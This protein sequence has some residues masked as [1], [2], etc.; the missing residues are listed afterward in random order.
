MRYRMPAALLAALCSLLI[1]C[2]SP[3]ADSAKT[4][5]A[6]NA[7]QPAVDAAA[8]PIAER[9][10]AVERVDDAAIIANASHGRE[11]LTY[12][13]GFSEQRYSRLKQ[14]NVDNVDRLGLAWSYNLGSTRGVEATPVVV[15][16]TMYVTAS[17]S[18]VHALDARTGEK[19][20]QYDPQ[21][22]REYGARACCDVVNRGVA[23]AKGKVFVGTLDGYLVALDPAT[24]EV[25]WRTDTFGHMREKKLQTITGAPR[26]FGD[27][28]VIGNGGA[29]LQT[30]GYLTAYNV[31]TGEQEWRWYSVPE[32]PEP[33]F[34]DASMEMAAKTWDPDGAWRETGGGG[35]MWDSMAYDPELGLLY[36]GV[37]NGNP[38]NQ[39]VRSPKGGDN[40]FLSSIVALKA[41]TGEYVWH[42]QEVPGDTW[43]FT[44]AQHIILADLEIDGEARKVLMHAPKNGFFFVIDRTDGSFISAE[45]FV[46]VNWAE[47]YDENGRPI[48]A[49]GARAKK[50]AREMRPSAYGAHNWHPMS[51]NPETGLV[52]IPAQGVPLAME[53]DPSFQPN[54]HQPGHPM[55]NLG[56]NIGHLVNTITPEAKPFGHLLAWD[57]VAQKE[58]WRQEYLSPWNGGTTTTAGGLVFQGSADARFIAYDAK[59]GDALWQVPVSSGV[60]AGP[61]TFEI[62]G[63]QYVS[64]AVGWG[65][66]YGLAQ[67]HSERMGTGRV[68]TFRLDGE[69]KM[70]EIP[71]AEDVRSTTLVSGYEYEAEDVGPGAQLYV[72]SCIFC[73]GVPGVNNGGSLPNPGYVDAS[74]LESLP[75]LLIEGAWSSRGMPSFK[76]KLSE[77]EA[78]QVAAFIQNTAESVA[79]QSK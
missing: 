24:G 58:V 73:H 57:P 49:E 43:D 51:F 27:L 2:S 35:T 4:E 20:W 69:A 59:T 38:W 61:S 14:I 78:E 46:D 36:V 17:W 22:P 26:V 41:K 39:D 63:T 34:A 6:A 5:S 54:T 31:H 79:K 44:A 18:V 16:D 70:P 1:A 53:S 40:L 28:V 60:I 74:V 30:R 15:G 64:I 56:W 67:R 50:A 21:V 48:I 76:G 33:P 47:G 52:Y 66:V 3:G 71:R 19:L 62:D 8:D 7:T 10:A 11:W 72:S 23:V 37:G 9:R 29:E 75:T 12:N 45:P 77:R 55:S 13:H 68:Y 42:Y 25:L 32:D 65:G